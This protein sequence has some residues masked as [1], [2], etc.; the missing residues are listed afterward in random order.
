[1]AKW[2]SKNGT[3][4]GQISKMVHN[5]ADFQNC[6]WHGKNLL[7]LIIEENNLIVL[8]YNYAIIVHFYEIAK[9]NNINFI[10]ELLHH[11]K[12]NS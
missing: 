12:K 3:W 6:A 10:F 1:M 8:D 11:N 9:D 7:H 5:R 4:D 2:I